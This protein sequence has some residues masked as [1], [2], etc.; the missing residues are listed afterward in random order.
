M[1]GSEFLAGLTLGK[2]IRVKNAQDYFT[3]LDFK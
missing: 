3:E 2:K 1:E